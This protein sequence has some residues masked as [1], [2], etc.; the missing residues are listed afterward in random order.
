MEVINIKTY[1]KKPILLKV[2]ISFKNMFRR[3]FIV[4]RGY[5]DTFKISNN[6]K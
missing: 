6:F 3:G 5:M 2:Y 4:S 1:G